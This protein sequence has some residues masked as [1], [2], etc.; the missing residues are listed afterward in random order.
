MVHPPIDAERTAPTHTSEPCIAGTI[1]IYHRG[2]LERLCGRDVVAQALTRLTTAERQEIVDALPVSW[3]RHATLEALYVET[4]KSADRD[5]AVLH[6]QI[7][8]QGI[9]HR[10][11]HLWRILI[12]L[13]S[14]DALAMRAKM[15][16]EK[17][18]SVGRVSVE[19]SGPTTTDLV[20]RDWPTMP[21]M[22]IRGIRVGAHTLLT[23]AGLKNPQ[24]TAQRLDDGAAIHMT[25][26]T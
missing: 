22:A 5:I 15:I 12:R 3:V 21:E 16:Y 13:S 2:A 10:V 8:R 7:V 23:L 24:V 25:R 1:V 11:R 18:Y 19:R 4:A 9:E 20:V 17:S 14:P 6:A 26:E